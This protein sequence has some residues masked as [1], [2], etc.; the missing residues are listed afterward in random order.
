MGI[1]FWTDRTWSEKQADDYLRDLRDEFSALAAD[2]HRGLKAD[3]IRADY[4]RKR[5]RSHVIFFLR[6]PDAIEIVRVLH[7]SMSFSRH[8]K[9]DE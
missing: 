3:D 1:W 9:D 5:F 7:S 4:W 8:L 2:P 6:R